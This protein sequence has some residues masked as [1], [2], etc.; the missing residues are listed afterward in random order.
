MDN[1]MEFDN[2]DPIPHTCPICGSGLTEHKS[3]KTHFVCCVDGCGI[4]WEDGNLMIPD[5]NVLE[6]EGD[7]D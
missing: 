6:Y 5:Y 3:N 4:I 7:R 2:K 1:Y